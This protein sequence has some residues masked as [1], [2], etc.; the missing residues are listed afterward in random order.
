[1][2]FFF[3]SHI[4]FF[5]YIIF[6]LNLVRGTLKLLTSE[7][8]VCKQVKHQSEV[9]IYS[10]IISFNY[11]TSVNSSMTTQQ[12]VLSIP[13][14]ICQLLYEEYSLGNNLFLYLYLDFQAI[15]FSFMQNTCERERIFKRNSASLCAIGGHREYSSKVFKDRWDVPSQ[16]K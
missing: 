13:P 12:L 15:F 2:V 16:I 9:S 14:A 5:L 11:I 1:M 8:L 6:Q 4:L 7:S 10:F 3:F